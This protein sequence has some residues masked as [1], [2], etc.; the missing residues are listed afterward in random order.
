[1]RILLANPNMT[2]AM[3]DSMALLATAAVPPG[4]EVIART[5][6]RGFPYI[7]SLAEAQIAGAICLE[8]LAEAPPVDAAIIAAFG[9]PGL[10]AARE[11]FDFPVVGMA[12][13]AI[14]T[15]VQ[16][17]GRFAIVTFT[18]AM[19]PWYMASVAALGMGARCLGV[20]T[21]DDRQAVQ[22]GDVAHTR[23]AAL[24]DLALGVAEQGAEVIIFGGA[25]LAGLAQDLVDD[26]PAILVDPIKAAVRQAYA[27][28]GQGA[29][30]KSRLARPLAKHSTGLAPALARRIARED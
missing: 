7:S 3:T 14:L 25:P 16:L 22:V 10:V 2:R 21:P 23:R 5:A 11:L 28:A 13:A 29:R 24:R 20:I 6:P 26:V 18:P 19:T 17:G 12:E 4:T 1:M 27:L 15:A 9:D 8:M 30:P